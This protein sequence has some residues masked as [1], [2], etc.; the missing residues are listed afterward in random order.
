VLAAPSVSTLWRVFVTVIAPLAMVNAPS[1]PKFSREISA[2]VIV[3]TLNVLP[4]L[5]NALMAL[6][7]SPS[8]V[9]NV[10]VCAAV[11]GVIGV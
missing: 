5:A 9:L 2:C 7:S 10:L 8:G 11:V 3:A 1:A 6:S 4:P